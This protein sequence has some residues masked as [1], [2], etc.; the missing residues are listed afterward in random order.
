MELRYLRDTDGR[1]IDFVVL[2]DKK[3]IFAVE[4]K[5][6]EKQLSPHIAYFRLRTPIPFF[7]QVHNGKADYGKETMGRVLPFITFYREL[8]EKHGPF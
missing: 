8:S 3:P 4:C 2:K 7:Y 5:T 6:G 1:E